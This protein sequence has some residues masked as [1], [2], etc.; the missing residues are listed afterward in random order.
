MRKCGGP[1]IDRN[2]HSTGI[3]SRRAPTLRCGG[4]DKNLGLAEASVVAVENHSLNF[5]HLLHEF[6]FLWIRKQGIKSTKGE[7]Q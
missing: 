5:P 1:A 3:A 6:R 7:E 4:R 2:C